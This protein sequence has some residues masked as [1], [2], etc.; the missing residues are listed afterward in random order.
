MGGRRASSTHDEQQAERLE[1]GIQR[2]C[3]PPRMQGVHM[4]NLRWG[5]W[6]LRPL[7][8]FFPLAII[9]LYPLKG[10]ATG[11]GQRAKL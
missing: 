9:S 1:R 8:V 5:F 3:I 2:K 6:D 10:R 7:K 4:G 11:G